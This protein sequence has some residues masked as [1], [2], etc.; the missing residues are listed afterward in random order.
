MT[1]PATIPVI[2]DTDIGNDIDDCI[3]LSYLLQQSRC[4]LLGVTTVSGPT[5]HRAAMADAL[6]RAAGR[7]DI[8]IHAGIDRRIV[9]GEV[10]QPDIPQFEVLAKHPHREPDDFENYSA[11]DF[12]RRAIRARPGEITLLGIGPMTNLGVL[13]ASDPQ[14]PSLLKRLV[15]MC[16]VFTGRQLNSPRT[17]W[18]AK[19][20][21]IA[22]SIVYR[23]RPPE[24]I[25]IGLD[26]TLSCRKPAAECMQR[27]RAMGGPFAITADATEVFAR[28]RS[29]VIFHDPLAAAVI[30]E[31]GVC[32][33]RAGEVT[34]DITSALA[35]GGTFFKESESGPHR[36]AWEVD[37]DRFFAHFFG[38]QNA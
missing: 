20:D 19:L 38:V 37:I 14:I 6:C 25:S 32:Q 11:V 27:F 4:E 29:A 5:R 2:L 28:N 8:P 9:G 7:S 18:N 33:Y 12:L 21:P 3:C 36:V 35:P 15:L 30:F 1:E 34:V 23:A 26:V 13:F 24:H 31:P 17:E 22:T 10:I 16:G